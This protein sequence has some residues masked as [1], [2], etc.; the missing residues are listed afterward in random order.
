MGVPE[1]IF[2][3]LFHICPECGRYMTK[4]LSSYHHDED[5]DFD[6]TPPCI[7]IRT[8]SSTCWLKHLQRAGVCRVLQNFPTLPPLTSS[9]VEAQELE[10]E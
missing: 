7:Y 1:E 10:R 4:R 5:E 9:T 2:C 3:A 6:L 8:T